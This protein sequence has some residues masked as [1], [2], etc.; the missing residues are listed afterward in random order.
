MGSRGNREKA[1]CVVDFENFGWEFEVG[2]YEVGRGLG[3]V[4]AAD[5]VELVGFAL[6][7]GGGRLVK[8]PTPKLGPGFKRSRDAEGRKRVVLASPPRLADK[9]SLDGDGRMA[10]VDLGVGRRDIGRGRALDLA[11][12]GRLSSMVECLLGRVPFFFFFFFF[13]FAL[14]GE[15][16]GRIR[17][18]AT[19][20][21]GVGWARW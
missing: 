4:F 13:L 18:R 16:S 2:R 3:R 19:L 20:V 9:L 15:G 21:H 12:V 10:G 11:A 1:L 7:M 17:L 6:V 14:E 8:F 5:G